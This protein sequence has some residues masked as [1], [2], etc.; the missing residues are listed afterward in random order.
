MP[1][2]NVQKINNKKSI[3]LLLNRYIKDLENFWEFKI[4]YKPILFLI[5]SRKEIDYIR[6]VKTDN[7]LVGW[8]WR[9]KFLFILDQEK[10]ETDS[11][12]QKKDFN[13]ILKHEL[14]HFFFLQATKGTL[15]AWINEG[16]ACF[17]A[18]QK[19]EEKINQSSVGRLIAC[20][21]Q[22]DRSLFPYSYLLVKKLLDYKGKNNFINF[23]KSFRKN[24][25]EKEFKVL[26]K[27]FF[28]INFNKD[29]IYQL[30][31]K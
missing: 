31:I 29:D 25:N 9:D 2:L 30:L 7:R 13:V 4:E 5:K 14:S 23:L 21:Y 15:P 16:L 18:G 1:V 26:F 12:F 19:Y 20:H 8:F 10:F 17:I 3:Q 22:F 11:D 28:Q 6:G 24:V 27:K